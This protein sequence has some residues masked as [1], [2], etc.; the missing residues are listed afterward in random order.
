MHGAYFSDPC[1]LT[2][3]KYKKFKLS[4]TFS[5][6]L[7]CILVVKSGQVDAKT[8]QLSKCF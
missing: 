5:L 7:T 6:N 4:M 3:K 8:R 2:I 1:F